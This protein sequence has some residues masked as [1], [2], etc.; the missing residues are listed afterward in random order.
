[1]TAG[2]Q[3][4]TCARRRVFLTAFSEISASGRLNEA[5]PFAT[6]DKQ[7]GGFTAVFQ[8]RKG[9]ATKSRLGPQR[10]MSSRPYF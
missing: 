6:G 7:C 3:K 2:R 5:D 4:G 8:D 1:V 9:R 10:G